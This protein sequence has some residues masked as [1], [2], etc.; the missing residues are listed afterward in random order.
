MPDVGNLF[1]KFERCMVFSE[2]YVV[3]CP[4]EITFLDLLIFY[5]FLLYTIIFTVGPESWPAQL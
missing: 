2:R 5:L 4:T 3:R 1:T